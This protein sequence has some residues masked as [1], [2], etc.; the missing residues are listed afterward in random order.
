M[1]RVMR[2]CVYCASSGNTPPAYR[3]AAFELGAI[4]GKAGVVTVFGGGQIGSM[5]RLADGA[6]SV[7]GSVIG[8]MPR[9]M[10]EREW[11]HPDVRL[12]EWTENMAERKE[13]LIAGVDA[14]VALPGGSGTLEELLE[15][16]T[17]K[18]LGI[19]HQPVVVVNQSGFYDPLLAQFDRCIAE[20]FM[21]ETQ[22]DL[23]TVVNRI[24][25][26]LPVIIQQLS[27]KCTDPPS[28]D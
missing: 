23:F 4:F 7:G 12:F 8:I 26:V 3:Q 24:D 21:G 19:F 1:E 16:I 17:L 10:K 22:R 5:G 20:A 25:E 27:R 6:H 14:V 18:R 28:T 11:A 15:V 9:F 13:K 2:I